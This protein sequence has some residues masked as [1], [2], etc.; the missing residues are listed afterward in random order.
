[1]VTVN[2]HFVI[3]KKRLALFTNALLTVLIFPFIL[4]QPGNAISVTTDADIVK[5]KIRGLIV[6]YAIL[7]I[8]FCRIMM[9]HQRQVAYK[10]QI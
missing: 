6:T 1:M 9:R 3:Y 7:R 5:I 8:C 10:A 4:M 2:V